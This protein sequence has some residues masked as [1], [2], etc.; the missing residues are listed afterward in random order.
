MKTKLFFLVIFCILSFPVFSQ[1]WIPN[2]PAWG[3]RT[4]L[5]YSKLNYQPDGSWRGVDN[6]LTTGLQNSWVV[7][8]NDD[9][10]G[11]EASWYYDLGYAQLSG[12]KLYTGYGWPYE[13]LEWV[14]LQYSDNPDGPWYTALHQT[15]GTGYGYNWYSYTFPAKSARYWKVTGKPSAKAFVIWELGFYGNI[16]NI[17]S[18]S[19]N[20]T[21]VPTPNCLTL[22]GNY[23]NGNYFWSTGEN[24]KNI[25][26]CK[27]GKYTCNDAPVGIFISQFNDSLYTPNG[28]VYSI[29]RKGDSVYFGGSFTHLARPTGCGM[30][31]NLPGDLNVTNMPRPNGKIHLVIPDGYGGWY[32]AGDFTKIGLDSI[33][34][35]A[36]LKSDKKIDT[37]FHLNPNGRVN[38]LLIAGNKLYVGGAFT[39]V[40]DVVRNYLVM[41]DKA[42]GQAN[43][44]NSNVDGIVTS[45]ALYGSNLYVGGNFSNIGGQ[46][47]NKL[48]AVDTVN[49]LATTWNPNANGLVR[50]LLL[51]GLKLYVSGDFTTIS[52]QPRTRL[53]SY[54][55]STGNLDTWSP[56]P[57]GTVYDIAVAGPGVS[58]YPGAIYVCG[59][60]TTIGSASRTYI[61]GLDNTNGNAIPWTQT[62]NDT[63]L[64]V[65]IYGNRLFAGG[66]F[67]ILNSNSVMALT[68]FD[69]NNSGQN[70][71]SWLPQI[72]GTTSTAAYVSS[73]AVNG[74]QIYAGG[75]FFGRNTSG[76]RQNIAAINAVT[77]LPLTFNPY[78]NGLV[79]SLHIN[80]NYL[81][82]G[83]D[84]TTIYDQGISTTL[85]RN[86]IAQITL[87][88]NGNI[89]GWNP[90]ANGSVTSL[91]SKGIYLYAGG[92]FTTIGG[93]SR[94][95][96]SAL[97]ISD[98]TSSTWTPSPNDTVKSLVV[99]GD[100]LYV[101][102]DFTTISSSTRNRIASFNLISNTLTSF[103]PNA[104]GEINALAFKYNTLYIGGSFTTIGGQSRN[105]FS[106]YYVKTGSLQS[107]QLN[108]S[109]TGNILTSLSVGDSSIYAGGIYAVT[110]IGSLKNYNSSAFKANE[111]SR[112]QWWHPD[113]N[114]LVRTMFLYKDKIYLGGDFTESLN[115]YQPFFVA[116][117]NFC[118]VNNFLPVPSD[119]NFCQ[120][121]SVPLWAAFGLGYKYQW[122]KDNVLLPGATKRYYI[123]IAT[124]WYKALITD[125]INYGSL[126]TNA[127][128]VTVD[129]LASTVIT[130]SGSL[131]FCGAA[132]QSVTL[133]AASG[134]SYSYQW[135]KNNVIISGANSKNYIA[136]T[137]GAYYCVVYNASGCP[138]QSETITVNATG[139]S[140]TITLTGNNPFC[141]GTT[142]TLTSNLSS[143]YF[144]QWYKDNVKMA[145]STGQSLIVSVAGAYKVRD[146]I[147]TCAGFSNVMTLTVNPLPGAAG[148]ITGE[149]TI[150]PSVT[151]A[152]F[153]TA[154]V[155]NAT[156]YIWTLPTGATGTSSTTSITV[157]FGAGFTGGNITVKGHNSCGDGTAKS[158]LLYKG[159]LPSAAGNISGEDTICPGVTLATY[160]VAAI[161]NAMSYIWTL[162]S[163]MTGSSSTR[164][165]TVTIAPSFSGGQISVKGHNPCG[166]GNPSSLTIAKG[167]IPSA[168]GNI[169]GPGLVCS[170]PVLAVYSVP[171]I[172][173]ATSYVWILPAGATGTSTT[174]NIDVTFT[175][176]FTGGTITVQGHNQCGDGAGSSLVVAKGQIPGSAGT[177]SGPAT[178]FKGST[179][180]IYQ[181]NPVA[182]ATSYLW[183]LPPGASGSSVSNSITVNFSAQASSGNITVKPQS[184]CGD[185]PVSTLYVTL[186]APPPQ[187]APVTTCGSKGAPNNAAV[188]VPIT[189]TGFDSITSL[190]LR[191]DYDP[192][193]LTWI[194]F[195]N[196]NPTL[197]GLIV[198]NVPVSATLRKVL[199]VWTD[200]NPKTLPANSKIVDLNFT[201]ISGTTLLNWNNESNGG[202]DCEYADKNGDPLWDVPS[203]Q[204]YINGD[205]HLQLGY[206]V[207]GNF[208]YNNTGSTILDNIKVVLKQNSAR[209]DSANTNTQGYY[210]FPIVP[211]NTYTIEGN[212]TKPW[213]GVNGTDALK[214]Q[215]HFA[216]LELLT[217]PVR[218][219]AADVNLSNS[220]NGTDAL[221]VKRRFAGLDTSFTRGNWTFA[222]QVI[223]GDTVI[224]SGADVT[225]NFYGLC[226]GDVNG[227]NTPSPGKSLTSLITLETSGSVDV[228]TGKEFIFPVRIAQDARLGA[229]S[230]VLYFPSEFLSVMDISI[231]GQSITS[232]VAGNQ[233]RL[234]WSEPDAMAL[235]QNDE[236][237]LIRFMMINSLDAGQ[238]LGLSLGN[239]SEMADGWANPIVCTL[240]APTITPSKLNGTDEPGASL[241][242]CMVY[243]NPATE[244]LTV[245]FNL[246]SGSPV[247][248]SLIDLT[249]KQIDILLLEE[250]P[251]GYFKR[252]F[253]LNALPPGVYTVKINS[254]GEKLWNY[255]KKLVIAPK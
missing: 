217:E 116:V 160:S 32:L 102:G 42:T 6:I 159:A 56:N 100:S 173:G 222:K 107:M 218:L 112:S 53:A 69:L 110:N 219:L 24:T 197:S 130:A 196:A 205:V 220:I 162:P 233:I 7:P 234:A 251:K 167:A 96:L 57:N 237:L 253:H 137:S 67:T 154:P 109:S 227:S 94:P 76:T 3:Y 10:W 87:G 71:T 35:I 45:I 155:T 135:Y 91:V 23:G 180:V 73:I 193:L 48:A 166:D 170:T 122:Y 224:V 241:Q 199:M 90:D 221:K 207:S 43:S 61:A 86:R 124:G 238:S 201:H 244:Q 140:P 176:S 215:R 111:S 191:L 88:T 118:S 156:S 138:K 72:V 113:P 127:R 121:D 125:S 248:I 119:T 74:Y 19:F 142:V 5:N 104:N 8:G 33:K 85:P 171:V 255:Y 165:I 168:A 189:V 254:S 239:E 243:P 50:K 163:G 30:L 63:V 13:T 161:T 79:R 158:L 229:V 200:I 236:L 101:G 188:S 47:R 28:K 203:S 223:G 27:S 108:P 242:N 21:T 194:G 213:A 204:F 25:V 103:D 179:G 146:S 114:G 190:S 17:S 178:V 16:M 15:F 195:S 26:V 46:A 2:D 34:Y 29:V 51:N 120:G 210:E 62:F 92:A 169:T 93:N 49:A 153:S 145:G 246:L 14:D 60:F 12:F 64:S 58:Y 184:A 4:D 214:I 65:A 206:K 212:T 31:I 99:G 75:N 232:H 231:P 84:F 157:T 252:T 141:Q 152:V 77:G 38:A 149:D 172:S 150:C 235:K 82:V 66:R 216:G 106:S 98:G 68:S 181:V 36:H 147:S 247:Q 105:C 226:V 187:F 198:N 177:I 139:L 115:I 192:T 174:S 54:T 59:K 250:L 81:Y 143:G 37:A 245:E 1:N 9:V 175:P 144:H 39:K 89:T 52:S 132:G 133:T 202:S 186:L 230:L 183:T 249:G 208:V 123:P 148:N 70:I 209:I 136:T 164:T 126:F 97:K 128:H 18:L 131:I 134:T 129:P 83:G 55:L 211:D 41:V 151:S 22:S 182:G 11:L 78:T 95:R 44:W 20:Y 40:G 240:S 185:G 117:D 228:E 225:A 80:G